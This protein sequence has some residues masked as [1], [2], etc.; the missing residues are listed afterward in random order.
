MYKIPTS[1]ANC[2]QNKLI[3]RLTARAVSKTKCFWKT[4]GAQI[5]TCENFQKSR[6]NWDDSM[7]L[8]QIQF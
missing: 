7:C 1:N 8:K 5:G 3:V 2:Q 6:N 4:G